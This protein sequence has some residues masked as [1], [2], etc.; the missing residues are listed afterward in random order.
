MLFSLHKKGTLFS[1][2]DKIVNPFITI[3]SVNPV[4]NEYLKNTEYKYIKNIENNKTKNLLF[5]EKYSESLTILP[6][7]VFLSLTTIIYYFYS[8]R[9]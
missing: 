8:K 3:R 6:S 5:E 4:L 1:N 7:M 2:R 9:T